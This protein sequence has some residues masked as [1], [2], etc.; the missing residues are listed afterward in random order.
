[1]GLFLIIFLEFYNVSF[2]LKNIVLWNNLSVIIAHVFQNK[3]S[4]DI[5]Q[6]P[7]E[8]VRV[9]CLLAALGLSGL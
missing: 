1:M 2:T 6:C 4:Y 5:Q 8:N 9:F 7:G 3:E